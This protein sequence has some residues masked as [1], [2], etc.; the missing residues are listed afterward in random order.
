MSFLQPWMLIALPLISLPI[1]IHLINQWRYQTRPWGAMMFLLAANRMNRGLAKLRQWLILAMRVLAL[2]GLI[3]AVARPL[4]SNIWGVGGSQID[5]SL[6]LLDRSPSMQQQA[7]GGETKL[8][9]ARRQLASALETLGVSHWLGVHSPG[10]A[11]QSFET[12]DAMLESPASGPWSAS[13]DIPGLL[14]SSL[15]YLTT[16]SP[17]P[18]EIW[19]CSD[20]RKSDWNPE[21][22]TWSLIREGFQNWPQSVHFNLIAYPQSADQNLAIRVTSAR[23]ETRPTSSTEPVSGSGNTLLLSLQIQRFGTKLSEAVTVPVQIEIEGARSELSVEL[24]GSLAE[25]RDYRIPLTG[26]QVR[27]WGM[28]SVPADDN[29]ADNDYYFVFDDPPVQRV[30]LV[31]EDREAT[32]ALEIAAS[33]TANGIGNGQVEVVTPEQLDSLLLE[34]TALL[35]WQTALPDTSLA[36]AVDKYVSGGGQV[37]FFPPSSLV[38]GS[39]SLNTYHGVAWVTWKGTEEPVMVENWRGDQDLLAATASG[40]GLPVGQLK[41]DGHATLDGEVSKLAV[42]SGGDALLARVPT[43]QGGIYFCTASVDRRNSSLAE[44]GI[45]MFIAVQRA[46][47]QGQLALGATSNQ[48]ATSE[49]LATDAWTQLA[50]PRDILSTEFSAQA[51]I[52]QAGEGLFAINRSAV[53]DATDLVSDEELRRLFEG[54]NFSRI[55]DQA[56]NLVGLVREIWRLFLLAMIGALLFEA[57]LCLPRRARRELSPPNF[58]TSNQIRPSKTTWP[59]EQQKQVVA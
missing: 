36:P 17:G 15:E 9:T 18:S 41:I 54:L 58:S 5:T 25:I 50:G 40:I 51:G 57:W 29:L 34:D 42:L 49:P 53:E 31:S 27:G 26:N 7:T 48:V 21:S 43:E 37:M 22:G 2:T 46:I 20:L 3:L 44:N 23:R 55:E 59:A 13:T 19:I 47:Q 4:A 52:F 45:V 38:R 8:A 11:P 39:T 28:V 12:S 33:L 6:I 14:E 1:I 30:V 24:T 32:R 56:G 35:L 10:V 16:N